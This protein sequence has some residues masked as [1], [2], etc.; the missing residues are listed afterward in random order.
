[1]QVCRHSYKRQS[2]KWNFKDFYLYSAIF[3]FSGKCSSHP[4]SAAPLQWGAAAG[5]GHPHVS[6]Q[7]GLPLRLESVLEGGRQHQHLHLEGEQELRSAA[8][9]RPLQLEQHP[10][11]P[12]RPVE[13]GGLCDLWGHPGLPVCSHR[14]TEERPVFP[15]LT[16]FTQ[17]M[18]MDWIC[19]CSHS[20]SSDYFLLSMNHVF[21]VTVWTIQN[22]I[23]N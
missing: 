8:E 13:E 2:R 11:A 22:K 21:L 14:D 7:Q 18:I 1:M 3:L 9:G 10:E 23:T 19:L 12:C 6:G 17:T 16:W 4:D 15:V 5:E 20:F